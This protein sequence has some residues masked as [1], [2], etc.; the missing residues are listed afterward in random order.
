MTPLTRAHDA[1][2][3]GERRRGQRPR[4]GGRPLNLRASQS[5]L[6]VRVRFLRWRN[7]RTRSR[8]SARTSL[9]REDRRAHAAGQDLIRTAG[10]RRKKRGESSR[11]WGGPLPG[12]FCPE[13]ALR[14]I[15]WYRRVP[16]A[17]RVPINASSHRAPNGERPSLPDR[18]A[19][20]LSSPNSRGCQNATRPSAQ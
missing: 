2:S 3:V 5:A 14:K 20:V 13:R 6:V 8:I 18:T 1:P 7:R 4:R 17:G 9:G 10:D 11:G 19:S 16:C 12:Q 15:L